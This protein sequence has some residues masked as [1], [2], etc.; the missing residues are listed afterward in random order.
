MIKF[1]RHCAG[2]DLRQDELT[3]MDCH[4]FGGGGP[5]SV[6]GPSAERLKSVK[7]VGTDSNGRDTES[8]SFVLN[9]VVP[10]VPAQLVRITT[11]YFVDK[12]QLLLDH[13]EAERRRELERLGHQ[14]SAEE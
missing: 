10:V 8:L 4:Y 14:H 12:A 2:Y 1:F 5:I 6:E 7:P 9:S 13:F 11:K 3:E